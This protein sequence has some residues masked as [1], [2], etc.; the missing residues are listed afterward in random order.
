MPC[1]KC[2][3][4]SWYCKLLFS[5]NTSCSQ[6]EGDIYQLFCVVLFCDLGLV[7]IWASETDR[8]SHLV[9]SYISNVSF[10][11][12]CDNISW[13]KG[14]TDLPKATHYHF[15]TTTKYQS[16]IPI[17]PFQ[18]FYKTSLNCISCIMQLLFNS[19]QTSLSETDNTI[20]S[21]SEW[22]LVLCHTITT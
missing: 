3:L 22:S 14:F 17:L 21:S 11:T 9:F 6:Q 18:T 15:K 16:P 5:C 2:Y 13:L 8:H 1:N 20:Y 19:V 10:V 4:G 12:N 7:Q